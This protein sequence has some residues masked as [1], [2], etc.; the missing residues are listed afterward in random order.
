MSFERMYV[1]NKGSLLSAKTLQGKKFEFNNVE[2]GSGIIN[3]QPEAQTDLQQKEIEC[4][5][6]SIKIVNTNQ[7]RVS[8]LLTN[9]NLANAFYFREIGLFATDPDTNEKVL[10][11][12]ANAGE[13][14]EYI[15]NSQTSVIEKY[16]NINVAIDNS[17]NI[18][19]NVDPTQAYVS[20]EEFEES[21]KGVQNEIKQAVSTVYKP[22][23]SV[24]YYANLPTENNTVGDVY[25]VKKATKG[26]CK[27]GDNVVWVGTDQSNDGWDILAGTV[28]LSDY[29]TTESADNKYVAKTSAEPTTT[30]LLSANF[31]L[32]GEAYK[33]NISD[34]R[35]KATS[36]VMVNPA[37]ASRAIVDEASFEP[38][39]D[40]A[41]GQATVYCKNQPS[42]DIIVTYAIIGG[43]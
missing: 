17:E 21:I 5:I 7:V 20:Q 9:K 23:G 35:I 34:T 1:T 6:N 28:D 37:R 10:Y 27:A 24:E 29:Q 19:I 2:I 40:I 18:I 38:D 14:A 30:T 42:G 32:E 33:C 25:N 8:F 26:V 43:A 3:G 15:N 13:N 31:V 22:K 41:E 16:I 12:Y 4:E 39:V 11:A 36:I